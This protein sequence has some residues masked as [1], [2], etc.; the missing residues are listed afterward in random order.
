[1]A[2]P[3]GLGT[4][5]LAPKIIQF[6]YGE[7]FFNAAS[8]LKIL[9]WAEVLVFVNYLGGQ[10]LNVIDKQNAYTKIIGITAGVNILLN[11]ILI[12][13]HTYIGASVAT[14]LCEVLVFVLIY[15]TTRR[16]FIKVNLLPLLWRP[17]IG[18][19]GM[20]IIILNIDFLPL[21][22][23]V[24]IGGISYVLLFFLLGGFN[25]QDREILSEMLIMVGL[26]KA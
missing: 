6:V 1:M 21:W 22:Y 26:K 19:I 24:P 18:S 10:L 8:A 7:G 2:A 17:I 20:G 15:Q 5:L 12:P 3:I 13:K 9:I 14:L 23:L 11:V 25:A 4:Y 16:F